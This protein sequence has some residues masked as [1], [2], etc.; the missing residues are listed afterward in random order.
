MMDGEFTVASGDHISEP[1]GKK[2]NIQFVSIFSN[3]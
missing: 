2:Q 1:G 3:S